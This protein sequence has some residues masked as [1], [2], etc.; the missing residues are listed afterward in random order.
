MR[1]L[2]CIRRW[3]LCCWNKLTEVWRM[4]WSKRRQRG[5]VPCAA[6]DT[7]GKASL[8][9]FLGL[10][11]I[12]PELDHISLIWSVT[13]LVTLQFSCAQ[14]G[15]KLPC[16]SSRFPVCSRAHRR[17][18]C[19]PPCYGPVGRGRGRRTRYHWRGTQRCWRSPRRR[20]HGERPIE[21][22]NLT[23]WLA[24]ENGSAMGVEGKKAPLWR[25]NMMVEILQG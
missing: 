24:C 6:R 25:A 12:C 11:P 17:R 18:R 23:L 14:L 8:G 15:P 2:R 1:G 7:S 10:P 21:G 5:S 9:N 16:I 19:T 4:P 22:E 13:L 20:R 3:S